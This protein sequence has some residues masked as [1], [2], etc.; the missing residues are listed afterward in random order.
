MRRDFLR[1]LG[2][3]DKETIDKILDE[4]SFDI[5]KA[6][7][8]VDD[9]KQQITNL[10]K[11]KSDLEKDLNELKTSTGDYDSLKEQITTLKQD[12][13]DLENQ[14]NTK[15]SQ[16]QKNHAIESGVRDAKAKNIKAV[17]AQL[18]MDKITFEDG[19]LS[20]LSEQLDALTKSEA[21]SFLFGETKN[22]SPA[23]TNPNNPD[24]KGSG[25]NAPTGKTFTEAIAA[26]LNSNN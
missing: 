1:S 13:S 6:K 17:M 14:L 8:E 23:G 21:T 25:G 24:Y 12:K 2:I 15:I 11:D 7:G 16:L 4:N 9:L 19:E 20:G 22:P 3:E 18:D 10:K 26:A 5:G